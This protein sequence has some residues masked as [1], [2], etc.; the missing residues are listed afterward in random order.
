MVTLK[1]K[2][3]ERFIKKMIKKENSPISKED[4][5]LAK[6]IK[7]TM[8]ELKVEG[9]DRKGKIEYEMSNFDKWFYWIM[10]AIWASSV[11]ILIL[12][13]WWLLTK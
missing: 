5:K 8:S 2:D 12:L 1:G 3:A 9:G 11:W 10:G 4:R 7:K 13:T 6:E